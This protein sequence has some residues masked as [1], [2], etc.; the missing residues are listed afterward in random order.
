MYADSSA[1]L[2]RGLPLTRFLSSF[3]VR[4]TLGY[5]RADLLEE[6]E[7]TLKRAKA[8]LMRCRWTPVTDTICSFTVV[9]GGSEQP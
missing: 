9:L 5:V 4:D 2:T 3:G 7:R 8:E 6:F 1:D